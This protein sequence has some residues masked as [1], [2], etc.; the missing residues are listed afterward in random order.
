M[1]LSEK[2]T[3]FEQYIKSRDDEVEKLK[4]KLSLAESQ[5]ERIV[6][7]LVDAQEDVSVLFVR[8]DAV[9]KTQLELKRDL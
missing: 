3:N 1:V 5:L 4:F 9:D 6:P 7:M 2:V 8:L